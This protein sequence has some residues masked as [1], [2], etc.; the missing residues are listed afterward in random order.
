MSG[1]AS[2]VS[3]GRKKGWIER[4]QL[5]QG[6]VENAAQKQL[7]FPNLWIISLVAKPGSQLFYMNPLKGVNGTFHSINGSVKNNN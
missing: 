1:E 3:G 6:A 4:I 7:N 2:G 5:I